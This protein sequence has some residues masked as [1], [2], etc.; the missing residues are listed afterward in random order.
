MKWTYNVNRGLTYSDDSTITLTFGLS[1]AIVRKMLLYKS[2]ANNG[3][4]DNEDSYEKL[5]DIPGHWIR[6]SFEKEL[7]FAIEV[8]E[9]IVDFDGVTIETRGNLKNTLDLLISK[10]HIFEE[11]DYSYIN[12]L[13]NIDLGDSE[14]HGGVDN[15]IYWVLVSKNFDYLT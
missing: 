3:R 13:D 1:R 12:R 4:F 2:D 10:G 8:L 7:L 5:F 14:K 6:L 9:G 15:L 11:A